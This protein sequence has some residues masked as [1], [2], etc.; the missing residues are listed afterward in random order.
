MRNGAMGA[1]LMTAETQ[2]AYGELLLRRDGP[3]DRDRAATL[4]ALA[5][6]VA[7]PRRLDSLRTARAGAR[8]R[9]RLTLL[10]L[11]ALA[12]EAAPR[13]AASRAGRCD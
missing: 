2:C 8:R 9:P 13:T 1:V 4:G 12:G 7:A 3:G 5:G 6:A 11:P 10:A